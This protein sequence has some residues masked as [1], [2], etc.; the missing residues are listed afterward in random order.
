MSNRGI[1]LQ[2]PQDGVVADRHAEALHQ[3]LARTAARAMAEQADNF[4]DPRRPP[5]I[6]G[7]N[8]RETV[9][10]R[11]SLTF[12]MRASPAAQQELHCHWLAL[13]WQILEVAVGPAMPP[14][15]S[16]SAIGANA[17]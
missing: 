9:G 7:S 4:H 11:S 14:S 1:P 16:L 3:A 17:D 10:E 5:R 12:F 13:D 6:R 2:L 8:R 15:A